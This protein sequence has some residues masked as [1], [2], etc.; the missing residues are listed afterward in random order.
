MT[1][2]MPLPYNVSSFSGLA[3]C[4]VFVPNFVV[5]HIVCSDGGC[6]PRTPNL[7]RE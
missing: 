1:M 3:F 7:K 2:G 4:V 6:T 5:L